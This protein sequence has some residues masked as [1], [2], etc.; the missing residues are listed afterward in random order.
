[1]I[2][3]LLSTSDVMGTAWFAAIAANV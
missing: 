2:P 1:L 3:S